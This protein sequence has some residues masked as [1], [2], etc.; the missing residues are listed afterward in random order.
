MN[1]LNYTCLDMV[2]FDLTNIILV[3]VPAQ[4]LKR[5]HYY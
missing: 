5:I 1:L 4:F 2:I 3:I